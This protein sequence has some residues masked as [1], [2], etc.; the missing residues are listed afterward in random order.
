MSK[1]NYRITEHD[2]DVLSSAAVVFATAADLC[3][4]AI[5]EG[6]QQRYIKTAE[7][8]ALVNKVGIV[9]ARQILADEC[10]K[11]IHNEGVLSMT[12]LLKHAKEIHEN[13]TRIQEYA[14]DPKSYTDPN[15]VKPWELYDGFD[16]C[17]KIM[18]R[19]FVIRGNI[20]SEDYIKIEST[21]KA[22]QKVNN[23]DLDLNSKFE[24]E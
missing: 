19:D 8:K 1:S 13:I 7:Y 18:I 11:K 15:D 10:R 17:A 16:T 12:S 5:E 23:N 22:M 20:P 14:I 3:V 24:Y 2:L 9:A 6:V 21:L 4:K